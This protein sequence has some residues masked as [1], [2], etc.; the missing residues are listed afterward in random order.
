MDQ[1]NKQFARSKSNFMQLN[2]CK[3]NLKDRHKQGSQVQ[4]VQYPNAESIANNFILPV[5]NSAPVKPAASAQ[6]KSS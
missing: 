4:Q 2:G 1:T 3:G 5:N 6:K